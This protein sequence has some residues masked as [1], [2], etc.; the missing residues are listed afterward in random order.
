MRGLKPRRNTCCS[1]NLE[2]LVIDTVNRR[3][4]DTDDK[5]AVCNSLY[6]YSAEWPAVV[7]LHRLW[8]YSDHNLPQLYLAIAR[9]RVNCS[10]VLYSEEGET[11]D[12][13]ADVIDLLEKLRDHVHIIR[14]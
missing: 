9:A 6:S 3:C 14:H 7:V 11:L 1:G 2:S 5:I 8:G 13:Y 10:V 12:D 4:K